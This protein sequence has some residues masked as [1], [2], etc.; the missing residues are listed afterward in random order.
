MM[1][2]HNTRSTYLR[3]MSKFVIILCCLNFG[4]E[5]QSSEN[6]TVEQTGD[7]ENKKKTSEIVQVGMRYEFD[8][9]EKLTEYELGENPKIG[10]TIINNNVKTLYIELKEAGG[11]LFPITCIDHDRPDRPPYNIGF[12]GFLECLTPLGRQAATAEPTYERK[13]E[14]GDEWHVEIEYGP[15]VKFPEPGNYFIELTFPMHDGEGNYEN[16]ERVLTKVIMHAPGDDT[17]S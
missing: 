12:D 9:T 3:V 14:P 6:D 16:E 2:N 5:N 1:T 11:Y 8:N 15:L 10:L 13:M 7:S 4:C 17:E